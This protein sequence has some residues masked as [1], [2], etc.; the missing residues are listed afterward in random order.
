MGGQCF[1]GILCLVNPCNPRLGKL[2]FCRGRAAV[3]KNAFA[4]KV[5]GCFIQGG[6][7]VLRC[8]VSGLLSLTWHVKVYET[9]PVR[10]VWENERKAL[11]KQGDLV[12]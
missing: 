6:F 1:F 7:W 8:Q 11:K 10:Y 4:E 9:G 12:K 2:L 3:F 5:L